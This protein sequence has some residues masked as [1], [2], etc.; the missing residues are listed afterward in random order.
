VAAIASTAIALAKPP[1]V[2]TPSV[3]TWLR[4]V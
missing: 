3:I 1:A 4:F 2:A